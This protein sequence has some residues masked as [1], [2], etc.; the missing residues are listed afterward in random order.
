MGECANNRDHVHGLYGPNPAAAACNICSGSIDGSG[1]YLCN[2]PSGISCQHTA[3]CPVGQAWR[4]P[5]KNI[6][7][8]SWK[9]TTGS[10]KGRPRSA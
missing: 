1:N 6:T 8:C 3:D 7:S 10:R 5:S 9:K 2:V 4:R